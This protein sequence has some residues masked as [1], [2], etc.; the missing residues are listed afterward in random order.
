[1]TDLY[2]WWV[3]VCRVRGWSLIV[4]G[5]CLRELVLGRRVGKGV[6]SVKFFLWVCVWAECVLVSGFFFCFVCKFWCFFLFGSVPIL[7]PVQ[8]Q[9]CVWGG[10]GSGVGG[11]CVKRCCVCMFGCWCGVGVGVPVRRGFFVF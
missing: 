8:C 2:P 11:G 4:V 7:S 1:M 3:C 5:L 9:V 10:F 6:L